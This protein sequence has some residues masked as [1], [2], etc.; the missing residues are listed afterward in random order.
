MSKEQNI[1]DFY[2]LCNRL[3]YVLR[4]GWIS[5]NVKADRLE[6][7]AE[8]I[9]GVQMLAIAIWSE[10]SYNIDLK[11]VLMM[12]SVHELEEIIIGDL[13]PFDL[14]KKTKKEKGHQAVE[15][16]LKNLSNADEI[17]NLILEFDECKTPE[18]VFANCCDKLECDIQCKLYDEKGYVCLEEQKNNKYLEVE[19]V[20]QF[21]NE[22]KNW[23]KAWLKFS[24]QL[25]NYDENF[26]KVSNYVVNNKI[27]NE[28]KTN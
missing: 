23:S 21:I 16:I 3:K 24:Q 26:L 10:Y 25:Y 7:V 9:Y 4:S 27:S 22:T 8:H 28:I 2:V 12:I 17:K 6:S 5:W 1:I 13:T 20:K 11:K 15:Q 18:A 19:L 14:D